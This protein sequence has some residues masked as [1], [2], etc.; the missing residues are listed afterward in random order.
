MLGASANDQV[1][2]TREA[3]LET[4]KP[5]AVVLFGDAEVLHALTK[6]YSVLKE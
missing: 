3:T 2:Q 6:K 5:I 4:L 1:R